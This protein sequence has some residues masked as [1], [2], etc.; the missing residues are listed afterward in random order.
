MQ[1]YNIIDE[2]NTLIEKNEIDISEFFNPKDSFK[3]EP[4]KHYIDSLRRLS[5]PETA[6][7]ELLRT[8]FFDILQ[9][10]PYTEVR[11]NSGFV[12]FVIS[13][14]DGNPLLLELKPLFTLHSSK[15]KIVIEPLEF[16]LHKNQILRYLKS[17]KNEYII[18]TDL[19]DCFLF[20]RT[21]IIDFQPFATLKFPDLLSQF[22]DTGN[23]WDT[24]TRI[25]DRSVSYNLDTKFFKDLKKW[26]EEFQRIKFLSNG[27]H[28]KEEL[29]VLLLN[30]IIFI[31][32]LEDY[33]LIPF[34]FLEESYNEKKQK[35]QV[36]G[37]NLVFK[38]FFPE[39][40]EY[41]DYFYDTEL[42]S[43]RIWDFI[44]KDE[45]NLDLFQEVFELVL[46]LD[47]WSKVFGH[48]MLHYNYRHINEDIFG[49]AYETFIAEQKKDSGIYYTPATITDYMS[50][51][52]VQ[53]LFT[54]LAEKIVAAVN[55]DNTNF[56]VADT[57]MDDFNKIT[58]VDPSS[59]SGSFLIK[60]LRHIYVEYQ[61]IDRATEW[62]KTFHIE[63]FADQPK[64]YIDTY[65]FR[66]RHL[67]NNPHALLSNI[68]LRHIFACDVDERAI[69]TAKTNIWK[70]AIKLNPKSYNYK[71]LNSKNNRILPNLGFNLHCG[72]SLADVPI[73]LQ[74]KI[75][76]EEHKE[77]IVALHSIRKK[78]LENTT[79]P[80]ILTESSG[81]VEKIRTRLKKEI[82]IEIENPLFI[83]CSFFFCWFDEHG[84]PLS[85]KV[86]GFS[87]IISNPPWEAIKPIKKEFAQK[88]KGE[89]NVLQFEKWFSGKLKTDDGFKNRWEVYQNF[90]ERYNSYLSQQYHNQGIGDPNYFKLFIERDIE[91][92]Q[93]D[94]FI[95]ILVPSGIQTDAGCSELRRLLIEQ[96]K[97]FEMTSFENRGFT[98]IRNDEEISMKFFPDVDNRFK[99]TVLF[100]EKK[101]NTD[102][103]KNFKARFYLQTP[104][105]IL[106]KSFI[107]YDFNTLKRFSPINLSI[108]EFRSE[109]D[110]ELCEKIRNDKTLLHEQGFKFRTEFHMTNDSHLF[111]ADSPSENFDKKRYLVLYEGK[112]I[113]QFHSKFGV[114][115]YRV[116]EKDGKEQLLET[117]KS[118]IKRALGIE[119]G[120]IE[121]FKPALD[122]ETYRLC[123]RAIASSTNE[124]SLICTILPPKVFV[125]HSMNYLANYSYELMKDKIIQNKLNPADNLYVMALLNS[126]TLN[127]YIRNKISANLTMNFL[128]ELP[129]P[130]PTAKQKKNIINKSCELL[131]SFSDKKTFQSLF[132]EVGFTSEKKTENITIRAELEV[133][134][135]KELFGLSRE[136]WFYLTSTFTFGGN[137]ETKAELVEII[138]LSKVRF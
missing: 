5:K 9:K 136:D 36:K 39:L 111:H 25:E 27:K 135:A 49:K 81:F 86:Q 41:F 122:Y 121:K 8:L 14:S 92:L 95:N 58:I 125:G 75:I 34:K 17:E 72:D 138:N 131:L 15:T 56:E 65:N 90:Y 54:P 31:K 108:M 13:E 45:K 99:F 117:E 112:M 85:Q 82:P 44:D 126:L 63:N 37:S 6:A 52:L 55:K 43:E 127:Y 97:L 88:D 69:E 18:L 110:F 114:H 21:A 83:C 98:Q 94:G 109:R 76:A 67:F 10:R 78:Y 102:P 89:M 79:N 123:Y 105:E 66:N 104:E 51:K 71:L 12:D 137:T 93:E 64:A 24:I 77:D 47:A 32:T 130:I 132:D 128:N 50:A 80:E 73:E 60:V 2:L 103:D 87:G 26:Y 106:D 124:R 84:N 11:E 134:I 19:R 96:N 59:G 61:K 29:I 42:F 101:N 120:L 100:G 30:K 16:E 20:N 48:G 7:N 3:Y 62:I 33:G 70:E 115:K 38:Y 113:H 119:N 133:I 23:I 107:S 74:I 28:T 91:L 22:L 116:F 1:P 118:R 40:E 57:L 4:I 129:L 46:G 68:I 53:T 35:W